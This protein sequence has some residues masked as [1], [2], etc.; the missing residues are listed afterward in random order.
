MRS[1]RPGIHSSVTNQNLETS[2]VKKPFN[3]EPMVMTAVTMAMETRLAIMAYSMEV[4]PVVSRP[5]LL[6]ADR[7]TSG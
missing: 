2:V 6:R 1:E 4:A 5:N 7:A 3:V